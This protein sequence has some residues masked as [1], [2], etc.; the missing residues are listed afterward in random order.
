VV[1]GGALGLDLAE[2]INLLAPFGHR[3]PSPTLLVPAARVEDP[4]P[5]GDE[6]QHARFTVASGGARARAVAFR[7]TAR[8]LS[9]Y[10]GQP[11]DVAVR[12]E[13]NEWN[14]T[15]E[16]R[17][18]L[19][20]LCEPREGSFEVLDDALGLWE[21]LELQLARP[22]A[23]SRHPARRETCD[24]RG[25]GV[26][27]VLGD[28][29]ASGED[30]LVA[31][32][33]PRRWRHG[34]EATLAG[35]TR[36]SAAI[37]SWD[38]LALLPALAEPYPHVLALDPPPVEDGSAFVAALPGVGLAHRAWG[39]GEEAI[40]RETVTA[41]ADVRATVASVYRALRDAGPV[42]RDELEALLDE[43]A[44]RAESAFAL[45]VLLELSLVT[46]EE[47]TVSLSDAGPT[48]LERS[49]AYRAER[50]RLERAAARLAPPAASRAAA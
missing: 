44:T 18:V 39:P 45:G 25:E 9:A 5:M 37:V 35:L 12:L 31:C 21:R 27:G 14:G 3:N 42:A 34:L 38:L 15:V 28:L 16:P 36:G 43:V 2:E 46:M 48:D 6:G 10:A 23:A 40:A 33:E 49:A 22:A 41:R 50:A 29:L 47:G 11:R 17:L 7:T 26:A 24:R 13:R 30:V 4:R 20:A 8:Y 1:P 32:G 19:R